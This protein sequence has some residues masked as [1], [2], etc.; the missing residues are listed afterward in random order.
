MQLPQLVTIC[1]VGPR[2]GL[3][4]ITTAI[5]SADKVRLV[6]GLIA[7]GLPRVEAGAFVHPKVVPQMAESAAVFS[8]VQ[9]VPGVRLRALVPNL[10]GAERAIA[11]GADEF[12][13]VLLASET[14]Q[15]K[16]VRASVAEA[17]Q[18]YAAVV[19]LA[20]A[21]GVRVQGG[22][23][24][25]FG[26]PYEGAVAAERVIDLVGRWV[27]LGVAEVSLADT[28]GMADPVQ[29][30]ALCSRLRERWPDL[31]LVLH[32]HNTRGLGLANVL[33]GLQAGVADFD[34]AIGGLGGCPFAPKATGNICTEDLVHMLEAM[35][36]ATGIDL[37]ALCDLAAWLQDG[38]GLQTPGLVAKAGPRSRRFPA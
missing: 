22:V 4:T 36:I 23:G 38:L 25:A 26:C 20:V 35:G 10:V 21:H 34:A 32:F 16:N 3:Q 8:G 27:D 13:L 19:A 28:T 5:S 37:A 9:R 17:L 24:T 15:R 12:C 31:R 7:A 1:D 14:F 29:V 33:A 6:D 2:D 30:Y 11:A 18:G